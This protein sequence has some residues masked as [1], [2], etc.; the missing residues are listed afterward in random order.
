MLG[1]VHKL[2]LSKTNISNV[3]NL[4]NVYTLH[5]SGCKNISDAT[6]AQPLNTLGERGCIKFRKCAYIKFI[7][8]YL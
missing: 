7:W 4:G 3:S 5:L 1:N 8:L 2:D 6:T